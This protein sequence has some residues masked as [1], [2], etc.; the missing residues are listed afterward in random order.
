M[1]FFHSGEGVVSVV[2]VSA[3][4]MKKL[5]LRTSTVGGGNVSRTPT[6]IL[7]LRIVTETS[8]SKSPKT[9]NGLKL[10]KHWGTCVLRKYKVSTLSQGIPDASEILQR[11]TLGKMLTPGMLLSCYERDSRPEPTASQQICPH[12]SRRSSVARNCVC[13]HFGSP[14]CDSAE[15]VPVGDAAACNTAEKVPTWR[16]LRCDAADEMLTCYGLC[17]CVWHI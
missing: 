11:C 12:P 17:V 4:D 16:L 15:K 3:A 8:P 10:S 14:N 1:P 6:I 9:N 13:S 2:C 7:R 5:L